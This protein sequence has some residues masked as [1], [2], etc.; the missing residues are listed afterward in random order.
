[1]KQQTIKDA[2]VIEGIGL[3]TGRE[4]RMTLNRRLLILVLSFK[5]PI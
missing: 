4:V 3:H 5:E 1:M 2:V